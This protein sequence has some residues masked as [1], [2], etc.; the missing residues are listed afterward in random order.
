MRVD[1]A[2]TPVKRTFGTLMTSDSAPFAT[3]RLLVWG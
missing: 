3:W 1:L 2:V